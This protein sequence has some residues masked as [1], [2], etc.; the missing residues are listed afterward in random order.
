MGFLS[1]DKFYSSLGISL[2]HDFDDIPLAKIG[3]GPAGNGCYF[4]PLSGSK[5][6]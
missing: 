2:K 3:Y 5:A 4:K 1:H 6:G